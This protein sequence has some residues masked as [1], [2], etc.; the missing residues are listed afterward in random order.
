MSPFLL[1]VSLS[2]QDRALGGAFTFAH[3][4]ASGFC[5]RTG[6]RAP[7]N[8]GKLSSFNNFFTKNTKKVCFSVTISVFWVSI[9]V[10]YFF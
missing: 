6:S 1:G 5:L 2:L 9:I 3:G 10:D 4:E 8:R 7:G